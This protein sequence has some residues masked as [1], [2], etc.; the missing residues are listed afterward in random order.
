MGLESLYAVL[1]KSIV[2]VP[3]TS[4]IVSGITD[5][6]DDEEEVEV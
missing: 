2:R 1:L 3:I 4:E 5:T 6:E